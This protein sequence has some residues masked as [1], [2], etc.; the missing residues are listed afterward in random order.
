MK[1]KERER[2]IEKNIDI[3]RLWENFH[4]NIHRNGNLFLIKVRP[5]ENCFSI[6]RQVQFVSSV[7]LLLRLS[8]EEEY[9]RGSCLI[10]SRG[11]NTSV[12]IDHRERSRIRIGTI[13]FTSK[14][15]RLLQLFMNVKD[16]GKFIFNLCNI[17][18]EFKQ[19]WFLNNCE[20]CIFEFN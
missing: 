16:I 2:E 17:I 7:S 5:E 13:C 12:F 6:V 20:F 9:L 14:Y 8:T 18:F 10:Y 15:S 11:E 3:S 1:E 19:V 4:L